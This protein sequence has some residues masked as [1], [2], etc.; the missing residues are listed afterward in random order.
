VKDLA[1]SQA[2]FVRAITTAEREELPEGAD[3]ANARLTP[4]P[5]MSPLERLQIYR[6]AY[7]RRLVECLADDFPALRHALGVAAFE[8]LCRDYVARHPSRSPSLNAYGAT[9]PSFCRNEAPGPFPLRSFAAEL[10][11]LEWAIVEVIHAPAAPPLSLDRLQ[12]VPPE[13]WDE[14]RLTPTAALRILRF[15]HPVNAYFQAFLNGD[16]G[17]PPEGAPSSVVVYRGGPTVW[18]MD[19]SD[20]MRAVLEALAG[21]EPLAAALQRAAEHLDALDEGDAARRVT[22]WF[23]EWV[24]SG[25]FTDIRLEHGPTR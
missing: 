9:M 6:G 10:A 12:N 20:A 7:H 11:A 2:W 23:R 21:G 5:R 3:E 24:S 8:S 22:A 18:R 4:G 1:S 19:L 15:D 17:A 14:A 16:A 13:R 25:F